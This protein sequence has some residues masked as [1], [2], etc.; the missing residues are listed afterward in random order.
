[1]ETV[2]FVTYF[3]RLITIMMK[4]GTVVHP[5]QDQRLV[6]VEDIFFMEKMEHVVRHHQQ[7]IGTEQFSLTIGLYE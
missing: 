2:Y 1:M 5:A 6:I 3:G 4:W 7:E